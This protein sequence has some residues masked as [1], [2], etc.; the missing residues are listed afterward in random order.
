MPTESPTATV[1]ILATDQSTVLSDGTAP[2]SSGRSAGDRVRKRL[3]SRP[4]NLM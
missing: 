1:R 4:K 3:G 2:A